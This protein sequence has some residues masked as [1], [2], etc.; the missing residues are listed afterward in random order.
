MSDMLHSD[1]TSGEDTLV[2]MSE[3][4]AAYAG[5][6]QMASA[7]QPDLIRTIHGTLAV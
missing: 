6:N 3:I 2:L 5:R 4:V 1:E 7:E